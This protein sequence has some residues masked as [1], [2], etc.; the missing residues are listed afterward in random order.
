M[1]AAAVQGRAVERATV[2]PIPGEIPPNQELSVRLRR[3][4]RVG[5]PLCDRPVGAAPGDPAIDLFLDE[6]RLF[7]D[8]LC[9]D[10]PAAL[11]SLEALERQ[12]ASPD[13]L[14]RLLSLRG[15]IFLGMG[16]PERAIDVV[17]YLLGQDQRRP[18]Q[19]ES[20]PAGFAWAESPGQASGWP[21]YLNQRLEDRR[22]ARASS[23][24]APDDPLRNRNLEVPG[25]APGLVVPFDR[26]A[27]GL[28][29]FDEIPFQ[30]QRGERF[31][32]PPP[33]FVPDERL[34]FQHQPIAPR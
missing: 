1:P 21:S 25:I 11:A 30:D 13:R 29:R 22:K 32:P 19:I 17:T 26:R 18:R 12:T 24:E 15:Q 14:L 31:P 10:F 23:T 5:R 33:P 28:R 8:Y 34:R 9:E 20:T 4:G 6:A 27:D 7:F 2:L 16:E 3:I